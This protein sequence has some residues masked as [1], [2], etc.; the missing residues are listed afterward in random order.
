MDKSE[1]D[2]IIEENG[3][4]KDVKK[5]TEWLATDEGLAYLSARMEDEITTLTDEQI[6]KW[7]DHEIPEERMKSRLL[8]TIKVKAKW[9]F[10]PWLAAAV[11]LP[12]LLLLY[13][14]WFVMD[15]TGVLTTPEMAEMIVPHGEHVQL[16]LQDGSVIHLNSGSKFKYPTKFGL[17][18][19]KVKLEGEGY[20]HIAKDVNRPFS[21]DL[22][23]VSVNVTGTIFN[24]EAYPNDKLVCIT[25]EKGG[26][27]VADQ[28]AKRYELSPGESAVYNRESGKCEITK[29]EDIDDY[30]GWR[31]KKL[32]FEHTPLKNIIQVL[33]R[34]YDVSFIVKD[35]TLLDNQFTL[36][37]DKESIESLLGDLEM[38]SRIHF[39]SKAKGLYVIEEKK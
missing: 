22:N 35:S 1:I 25:L 4:K 36:S 27:Y 31:E 8:N 30:I 20:F 16:V 33:E 17:F 34:Q 23:G 3:S 26:V 19:R 28:F 7:V 37:T 18:N 29:V 5:I 15:R 24:V 14:L 21:V 2:N 39:V 13:S 38:V 32:N 9:N 6:L 11:L 12:F 10:R